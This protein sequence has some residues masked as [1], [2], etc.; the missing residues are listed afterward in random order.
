MGTRTGNKPVLAV[1]GVGLI[2]GSLAID[3]KAAEMVNHVIG[4]GRSLENL[5]KAQA[6]GVIDEICDDP[7]VAVGKADVVVTR[8]RSLKTNLNSPPVHIPRR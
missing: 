8:G 6:R 5:E 2:G 7:G 4:V 3:L 1:F